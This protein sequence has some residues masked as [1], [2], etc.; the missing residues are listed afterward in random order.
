MNCIPPV[1]NILQ[2][3]TIVDNIYICTQNE[4]LKKKTS[5]ENNLMVQFF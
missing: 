3:V 1:F 4:F 2:Y 5:N